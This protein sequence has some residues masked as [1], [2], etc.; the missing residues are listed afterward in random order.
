MTSKRFLA[1]LIV[2]ALA[3]LAVSVPAVFAAATAQGV[4]LSSYSDC[5]V[6]GLDLTLPTVNASR[7]YGLAT[8][9][10]GNTI[11]EFEDSTGLSNFSGT[12]LGYHFPFSAQP[13]GTIITLYAYVGE[14]PPSPAD[15]AQFYLRYRCSSEGEQQVLDS[16]YGP[17]GTCWGGTAP[18]AAE[19]VPGCDIS[20]Y[21]PPQAVMG[22]FVAETPAY[23]APG[24]LTSPLVTIAEGKTYLVVGQDATGEYRKVLLQCTYVWVPANTVGP[25]PDA[26]W[27]NQPL[28]TTVVE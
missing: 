18:A 11:L 5:T 9:E 4:A 26:V 21:V 8:D 12:F 28:P 25:N 17:Y 7:E 14:T 6:A 10:G 22:R 3:G 24:K 27:N 2:L 23:W 16:C 20:V 13:D 15:T 1:S 19:P